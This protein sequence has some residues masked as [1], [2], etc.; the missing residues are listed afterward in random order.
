MNE[1]A[2]TTQT[3]DSDAAIDAFGEAVA[4]AIATGTEASTSMELVVGV[5]N[6]VNTK[7]RLGSAHSA[8][9]R[10]T[11]EATDLL[12]V[13]RAEVEAMERAARNRIAEMERQ[14][15]PLRAQMERMQDGIGA[16]NLY[17]GRDEYID[18][19]RDGQSAPAGTPLT[20]R[21]HV[22]A[23]DEESALL[24]EDGNGLDFKQ[25]GQF[26][27]W[28]LADE[29]NLDQ[30][31]PEKLGVVTIM[32]RRTPLDY[33]DLHTNIANNKK[34]AETWW[35]IRNGERLYLMNT[36]FSVGNKLVPARNDFTKLFTTAGHDGIRKPMEPGSRQWLEAEATADKLNRHYMKIALILQGLVDRTAV[37]HPL[38]EGG[39]NLLDQKAYENGLVN[40]IADDELAI[41]TGRPSFKDWQSKALA[42]LS[43]GQR[44]IG[45]FSDGYGDRSEH[46]STPANASNPQSLVPHTIVRGDGDS[47]TFL[48]ERTDTIYSRNYWGSDTQPKNRASWRLDRK[49]WGQQSYIPVD[50]V[51]IEDI[52][53]YLG[54]R[55]ERHAYSNMF[56]ALKAAKAL[57]AEEFATEAPYRQL[58]AAELQNQELATADEAEELVIELIVWWKTANKWFR[59]LNGDAEH[60][61]KSGNAIIRE[62]RRRK[63]AEGVASVA[64][65]VRAAVP[66]AMVIAVRTNDVIAVEAHERQYPEAAVAGNIWVRIHEFTPRG[67]AKSTTEW[68]T[69]SRAQVA[70]WT[71]LEA[72][73]QWAGWN[74][75][76][77][78]SVLS[79]PAIAQLVEYI[80]EDYRGVGQLARIRYHENLLKGRA[81][82]Q[83]F[84]ASEFQVRNAGWMSRPE[85]VTRELHQ[86]SIIKVITVEG[87]RGSFVSTDTRD[88]RDRGSSW[89]LPSRGFHDEAGDD[90]DCA[91]E[92]ATVN[93][94]GNI[95]QGSDV[96]VDEA[97]LAA[98][99]A[100]GIE[101]LI[102]RRAA[103]A[104]AAVLQ[105]R[106]TEIS[107]AWVADELETRRQRFIEDF[108][109]AGLWESHQKTQKAV[110]YPDVARSAVARLVKRLDDES[111]STSGLTVAEASALVPDVEG[112]PESIL[113]L[114]FA[115][116]EPDPEFVATDGEGS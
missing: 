1:N 56:P 83:T 18:E 51:S 89:K 41:G 53:Y 11:A 26:C 17:L 13:A 57:K 28:L 12:A 50:N 98:D 103:D 67:K 64:S 112:L 90:W 115:V 36:D 74:L 29:K 114:K 76:V 95:P 10:A 15:A 88:V 55:S 97:V 59:A 78:K 108:G 110:P 66:N 5:D 3:P 109:D 111:I 47:L 25:I 43:V 102:E 107:R 77:P 30:M 2:G 101:W 27:D 92:P 75:D 60:E 7:L 113:H 106:A 100:L 40:I 34:N 20:L 39:I 93:Y 8:I 31:L 91:V 86:P 69:L 63:N 24:S 82:V 58:L 37:F 73:E 9:A 44:V 72:N 105:A 62:A 99:K 94:S 22:L 38:P 35:I 49:P 79:D 84:G 33:G 81:T 96:W 48:Y 68:K 32:P 116:I 104:A 85:V 19:L 42:E 87:G 80:I 23:M 46:R 71:V 6:A 21:Q 52:D 54:S 4:R 16:V 14:L 70:K 45:W 61:K 65:L